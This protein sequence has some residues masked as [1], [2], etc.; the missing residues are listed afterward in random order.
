MFESPINRNGL[1]P[2]KWAELVH[3]YRGQIADQESLEAIHWGAI[4][5]VDGDGKLLH[6]VGDVTNFVHLRSTAKPFQMLPFL[7]RKLDEKFEIEEADIALFMASHGG[8]TQHLERLSRIMDKLHVKESELLCGVHAPTHEP[9]KNALIK[10]GIKSS[11]L[12]NNCSGKHCAMIAVSKEAGWDINSY[13]DK[14]HPLQREIVQILIHLSGTPELD[15]GIGID[16]CSAATFILPLNSM[17][18]LYAALAYP[19]HCEEKFRAVLKQAFQAGSRYP[20]VIAGSKRL[21][22]MLMQCAQGAIFAKTGAEGS[23]AIAVAPSAGFP[24]GIGIAVKVADGDPT[25]RARNQI[26]LSLLIQM[27]L[28][29]EES[30]AKSSD[31]SSILEGKLT[32]FRGTQVGS[33]KPVFRIK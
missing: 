6:S 27:G 21:D 5:V 15:L 26:V 9:S 10:S 3:L 32:N 16:G 33:I 31:L 22:T 28:L 20:E 11:V 4:A 29:A 2:A 17:A 30:I 13:I 24:K 19:N 23:Y 12:H 1:N 25:H 14:E 7:L 8:E 18:R